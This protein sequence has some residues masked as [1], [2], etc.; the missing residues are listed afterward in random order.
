[1]YKI[2]PSKIKLL[3]GK[4]DPMIKK[5]I[6]NISFLIQ[7]D[8]FFRKLK[9][10]VPKDNGILQNKINNRIP[11]LFSQYIYNNNQYNT[12]CLVFN[13][14]YAQSDEPL[15]LLYSGTFELGYSHNIYFNLDTNEYIHELSVSE[16]DRW[17][18]FSSTQWNAMYEHIIKFIAS[19][20]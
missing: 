12:P 2:N 6:D 18:H 20:L 5:D 10:I 13:I 7:E 3:Y 4:I 17:I 16:H 19:I 1:M 9:N 14:N 8:I 15:Y 11:Q